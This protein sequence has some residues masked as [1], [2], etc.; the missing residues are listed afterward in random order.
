M[1]SGRT[2][3]ELKHLLLT[4][5]EDAFDLRSWSGIP[6]SLRRAL[7]RQVSQ[8]TVFRPGLPSRHPVDV[9]KRIYHGGDP[10]RYPLALTNS[11]F[12][13]NAR[14]V[15]AEIVR[16]Q[17]DAVLSI[18]SPC[19]VKLGEVGRPVFMFGDAPWQAWHE[20]YSGTIS[21]P[22]M[23]ERV[24]RQEAEAARRLDGLCFGSDWAVAEAERLYSGGDPVIRARLQE[25]LHV[26]PLGA[27]WVPK[28]SREEVLARMEARGG[29]E[30]E[31]Q[32]LFV[33]KDWERKGGP[34]AVEIA[35]AM[36]AAGHPAHLHIVG[37]RPALAPETGDFVTVHGLLYQG[38]PD[39]SVV[40]AELF[41]KSH[42]LLV[43]TTAECFGIVFAEAQGFALPPVSRAIGALPTVVDDG[44]SGLLLSSD[45]PPSA[46]VERM[47]DL[48]S[49]PDA[50]RAMATE[51][52]N[53][54]EQVLTWDRT[55]EAI[56]TAIR[57]A[58]KR[59]AYA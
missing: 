33:G 1:A 48:H 20:T 38:D 35:R 12:R 26:T 2:P 9:L 15:R 39:E 24:A 34:L 18:S 25:R 40:L 47:L 45:A 32:L 51:A 21:R 28:A 58:V 11:T 23:F 55:A 43:P 50:Y 6:F 19:V 36:R 29:P 14:E 31:L 5:V 56:V 59:F 13:K 54:Y 49:R 30:S 3:R 37:C 16:T 27:N 17:P 42:F 57:E 41:S 4:T 46:Y 22:V 52:R 10:P 7:E 44:R 8:V 53:R